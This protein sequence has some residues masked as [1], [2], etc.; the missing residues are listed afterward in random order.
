MVLCMFLSYSELCHRDTERE[1]HREKHRNRWKAEREKYFF[2]AAFLRNVVLNFSFKNWAF[3]LVVLEYPVLFS[4]NI[5]QILYLM[6]EWTTLFCGRTVRYKS[7][8][9]LNKCGA[10]Q[11][12]AVNLLFPNLPSFLLYSL[13]SELITNSCRWAPYICLCCSSTLGRSF[14]YRINLLHPGPSVSVL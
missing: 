12:G 5:V 11:C 8:K 13:S 1:T 9:W 4:A 6:L 7:H 10:A 2:L 14:Y 3:N